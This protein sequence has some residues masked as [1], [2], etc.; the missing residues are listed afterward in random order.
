[1]DQHEQQAIKNK[2]EDSERIIRKTRKEINRI[3]ITARNLGVLGVLIGCAS[4]AVS[5][6]IAIELLSGE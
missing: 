6:Y 4:L 3:M 1:M 2:V 5:V